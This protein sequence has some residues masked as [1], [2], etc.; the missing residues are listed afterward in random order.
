[1]IAFWE[2]Q[3]GERGS[4]AL[5]A[6]PSAIA[7]ATM[8][9]RRNHSPFREPVS[10]HRDPTR[11]S[12]SRVRRPRDAVDDPRR[13]EALADDTGDLADICE[14]SVYVSLCVSRQ[15]AVLM[16][17]DLENL[18]RCTAVPRED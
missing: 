1:M 13:L 18:C 4:V 5:S 8:R 16:C 7:E 17:A 15:L 9:A 14:H 2:A 12:A 10:P 11:R 3:I 6:A